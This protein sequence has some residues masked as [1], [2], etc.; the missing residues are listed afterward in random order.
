MNS[1]GNT[2]VARL[3]CD[4][5]TAR[6]LVDLLSDNFDSAGT[7]MAAFEGTDRRWNVEIHFE[8]P[9]DEVTVRNLISQAA[10]ADDAVRL[11]FETVE[12]KDWVAASLADLKPVIAGRFTVHDAHDRAHVAPNLL[13]IEIE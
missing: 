12:A 7:A 9:P 5:R 11:V 13:G 8:D 1:R 6:R 10:G 2:T 4:A 3:V